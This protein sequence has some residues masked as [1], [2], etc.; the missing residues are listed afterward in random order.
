MG[1]PKYKGMLQ[2]LTQFRDQAAQA[3]VPQLGPHRKVTSAPTPDT[4]ETT[5]EPEEDRCGGGVDVP[6]RQT[7]RGDAGASPSP[8]FQFQPVTKPD[9]KTRKKHGSG[10]SKSKRMSKLKKEANEKA[11]GM[12]GDAPKLSDIT[13]LLQHPLSSTR[14]R[15]LP[16]QTTS[17]VTTAS[18]TSTNKD[19]RAVL[20][21]VTV[22]GCL[23]EVNDYV[24]RV[25]LSYDDD[26]TQPKCLQWA[27]FTNSPNVEDRQGCYGS[28]I[29][30]AFVR[31][32]SRF[33]R[34]QRVSIVFKESV[35]ECR[36]CKL[37]F[38]TVEGER[39]VGLQIFDFL[40]SPDF[41]SQQD[42]VK[43]KKW[44][45]A[46]GAFVEGGNPVCF[47][48]AVHV[49][50]VHWAAFIYYPGGLCS[51]NVPKEHPESSKPKPSTKKHADGVNC[52]VLALLFI[53]MSLAGV[54]S[55]GEDALKALNY[56]RLRYL[57]HGLALLSSKA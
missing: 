26:E 27:R 34:V 14:Y 43:R 10:E 24:S 12:G 46:H 32:S 36:Y 19:Y 45:G 21:K 28:G 38:T 41:T 3:I 39:V 35:L 57:R 20:V 4:A 17:H 56:Y 29:E 1:T 25:N 22:V 23:K 5:A 55:W 15:S 50:D 31:K 11:Y 16:P 54:P 40:I 53:E 2:A 7:Q 51:S 8:N 49:T 9:E 13:L 48:A 42:P 37:G 33:Q 47:V 30:V 44:A 18:D 6:P 52:G